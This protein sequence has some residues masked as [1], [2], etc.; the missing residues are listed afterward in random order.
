M[1]VESQLYLPD[2]AIAASE[3]PPGVI[4]FLLDNI[5]RQF[6]WPWDRLVVADTLESSSIAAALRQLP[7]RTLQVRDTGTCSVVPLRPY[8]ELLKAMRAKYRQNLNR[9]RRM[10]ASLE[11][12]EF[13]L[14][15]EPADVIRAFEEF[16]ELEASG[17]KGGKS[18]PRG[19]V[20]RPAAMALNEKKRRFYLSVVRAF[21]E[22]GAVE[23]PCLRSQGRL[24]GAEVWL[25]LGDT[26]YAL[27]TAYDE[28]FSRLSPGV[29]A[30]DLGYQHHVATRTCKAI[31]TITS[32][33][34]VDEWLPDKV[35]VQTLSL[36]NSS[37]RGRL[38]AAAMSLRNRLRAETSE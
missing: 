19:D 33:P 24:I 9:S 35:R 10:I 17:W 20:R 26:C 3:D 12:P 13:S 25:I 22:Q 8:D 21:A 15:S 2:C 4:A 23:I 6:D 29:M 37:L 30:F 31:N 18:H 36:F 28:R 27:K 5:A 16:I 11:D 7:G 1:P 34:A 38:F 14:V 32:T